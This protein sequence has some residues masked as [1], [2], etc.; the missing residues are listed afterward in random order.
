MIQNH[1]LIIAEAG[2]NHN[3]DLDRA[4]KLIDAAAD[5]GADI[6]KFQT[7]KAES[8]STRTAEMAAYQKENIGHVDSQFNMLKKLELK[9]EHH[10]VLID[11][12]QKRNIRFLS[13]GFDLESLNFLT[14]LKMGLWKVPS[15][16]M[17]NLPYLEYLAKQ[18]D[19]VILSTGMCDL[20]EIQQSVS[21]FTKLGFDQKKL[22]VLH[23]NTDYPTRFEDVHLNAMR[24]I[25]QKLDIPVGYSDHT[26]GIEVSI[27]AVALGAVVIEKHFTLDRQLPGPDHKASLEPNELKQMVTS[28]RNISKSLGR[29]EKKPTER[30]LLNRDIARKSI[31]TKTVIKAGELF[32]T[33]NLTTKRPGSGLNPMT[34]YQ[35]IGTRAKKDYN[36]DELV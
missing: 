23:C 14:T 11:H 20:A 17:T 27:A 5:A 13:T 3:G 6:V 15:G 31:V 34:W 12:C 9:Y 4:L 35:V 33:D 2:V 16:E 24:S 36:S 1:V 18:T 7:F 32:T 10:S 30:E 29:S 21:V 19:P 8:L 26:L 28:I 25:Q 22:T